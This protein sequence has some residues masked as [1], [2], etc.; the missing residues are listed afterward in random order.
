MKARERNDYVQ[1][2]S[3]VDSHCC[4]HCEKREDMM[5]GMQRAY[6]PD[7]TEE[8]ILVPFIELGL[9]FMNDAL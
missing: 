3:Y 9:T 5:G 1:I 4:V 8:L 6:R 7:I 2:E